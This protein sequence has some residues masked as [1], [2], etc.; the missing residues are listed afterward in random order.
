V[1]FAGGTTLVGS[2]P[3]LSKDLLLFDPATKSFS[4]LATPKLSGTGRRNLLATLGAD[5]LVH[6]LGGWD[7]SAFT[8]AHEVF[9]P[10]TLGLN[11]GPSGLLAPRENG[12]NGRIVPLQDGSLLVL[13][14]DSLTTTQPGNASEL[15]RLQ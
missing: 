4:L 12:V 14:Y 9:N 8:T 13:G 15:I 1:L 10:Q 2:S 11:P 3:T 5:G 6:L 7:G